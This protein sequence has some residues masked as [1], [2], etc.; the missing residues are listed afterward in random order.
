[1]VVWQRLYRDMKLSLFDPAIVRDMLKYSVPM[2]PTTIFWWV[3]SVSGQFL[4][5]SMCGDE[6]NGILPP[7]TRSRRC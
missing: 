2:I 3:T 1:M 4:V 5:K 7:R 6:A